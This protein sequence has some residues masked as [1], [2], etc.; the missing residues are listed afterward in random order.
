[1]GKFV[2]D[3]DFGMKF[4]NRDKTGDLK[5]TKTGRIRKAK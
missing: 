1:M 4:E 2:D 5:P 3:I